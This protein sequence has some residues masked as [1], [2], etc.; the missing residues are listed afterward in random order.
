LVEEG[1]AFFRL[2]PGIRAD[3]R[4]GIKRAAVVLAPADIPMVGRHFLFALFDS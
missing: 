4:F 1:I 2:F 3:I